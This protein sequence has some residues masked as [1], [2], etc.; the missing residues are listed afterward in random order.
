MNGPL[1]V[2]VIAIGVII[3]A[4]DDAKSAENYVELKGL[5]ANL[6]AF[7][8][9]N[10]GWELAVGRD[11]GPVRFS[12]NG[13]EH[14]HLDDATSALWGMGY[15]DKDMGP[16]TLYGGAGGGYSFDP[17]RPMAQL[18]AGVEIPIT[19]KWS[20]TLGGTYRYYFGPFGEDGQ[21]NLGLRRKF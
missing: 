11:Y 5:M 20:G 8:P 19:D 14:K 7:D 13:G 18:E 9:N 10:T 2:I 6:E 15:I 17:N 1:T 16:F 12:L 21:V 3:M 4:S